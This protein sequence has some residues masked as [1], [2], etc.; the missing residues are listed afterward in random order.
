VI[1]ATGSGCANGEAILR[2]RALPLLVIAGLDPANHL[3]SQNTRHFSMD[4]RVKP[5]GDERSVFTPPISRRLRPLGDR[6]QRA[7]GNATL[8]ALSVAIIQSD[9]NNMKLIA[10][11]GVKGR[12][13]IADCGNRRRYDRYCV[14]AQID[15]LI[16]DLRA[17]MPVKLPFG[18]APSGPSSPNYQM[19]L[20]ENIAIRQRK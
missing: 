7:A 2:R 11:G 8:A 4:H 14:S 16:F 15:K 3:T 9:A 18:P 20:L 12:R 13:T 5:G 17:P 19:K 1:G 6:D 10:K